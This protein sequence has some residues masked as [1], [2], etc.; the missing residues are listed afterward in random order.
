[1]FA[2]F[3]A[4]GPNVL[5]GIVGS[6]LSFWAFTVTLVIFII[7][8]VLFVTARHRLNQDPMTTA[9]LGNGELLRCSRWAIE[10]TEVYALGIWIVLAALVLQLF[11][12]FTV[13][14]THRHHRHALRSDPSSSTEEKAVAVSG[15]E[16]GIVAQPQTMGE[17]R[18]WM[19]RKKVAGTPVNMG[20]DMAGEGEAGAEMNSAGSAT[21]ES[22]TGSGSAAGTGD[23]VA[24]IEKKKFWG[25]GR[26]KNAS[27]V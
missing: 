6:I 15:A 10:L 8:L 21:G 5:L 24:L 14:F 27:P 25:M 7:D 4:S 22:T 3:V 26:K 17:K 2:L 20:G 12:S 16:A 9:R 18:D 23:G 19:G 11:A 1:M 13:C